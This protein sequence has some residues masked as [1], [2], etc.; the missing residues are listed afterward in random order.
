[1]P[2]TKPSS[3]EGIRID[4]GTK[5]RQILEDYNTSYRLQAILPSFAA[6][7]KDATAMY[8]IAVMIEIVT[9]KDI[10]GV[11]SPDDSAGEI[12]ESIRNWAGADENNIRGFFLPEDFLDFLVKTNP[13]TFPFA[14][15]QSVAE[16]VE[17]A[18]T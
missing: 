12:W 2:R 1:M 7:L 10:P 18:V 16:A 11:I 15:G 5:E 9:G 17:E 14:A 8:A 6:I 4:L 13:L 3:V